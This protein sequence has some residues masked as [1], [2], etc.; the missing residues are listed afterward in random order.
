MSIKS[1]M[2]YKLSAFFDRD[3]VSDV[4]LFLDADVICEKTVIFYEC[5]ETIAPE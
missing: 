2:G 3:Y 1:I 4:V 5:F